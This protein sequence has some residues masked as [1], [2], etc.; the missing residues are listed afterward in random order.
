MKSKNW[1][2]QA[3]QALV[4]A[5]ARAR[6]VAA[7]TNTP[8]HVMKDGKII[9]IMPQANPATSAPPTIASPR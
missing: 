5:A 1:I 6:A 2:Q 8:I 4:R 9:K 3:D 7:S